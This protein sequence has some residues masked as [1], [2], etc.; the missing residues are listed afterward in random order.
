MRE[1][2]H[3]TAERRTR[4]HARLIDNTA[5]EAAGGRLSTDEQIQR[6]TGCI[7]IDRNSC[8]PLSSHRKIASFPSLADS[9]GGSRK[10]AGPVAPAVTIP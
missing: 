6:G 7:C 8:L 9:L 4:C 1:P 10:I 2:I 5:K 3:G